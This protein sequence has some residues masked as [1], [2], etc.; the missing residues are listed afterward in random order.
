ML[1]AMKALYL[2]PDQ[3]P[4]EEPFVPDLSEGAEIGVYLA[5]LELIAE[6]LIITGDERII[7]VNSAACR[8]LE[9]SYRQLAGQALADLFT[10]ESAFLNARARLLIQGE[11][12]GKL[13]LVLPDGQT[14]EFSYIAAPRLRPG[15]HAIVLG[16]DPQPMLDALTV[17]ILNWQP[18]RAYPLELVFQPQ[19]QVR[20]QSL[21][22]GEVQFYWSPAEK[23]AQYFTSFPAVAA[24]LRAADETVSA[25]DFTTWALITACRAAAT[26]SR[27][28]QSGHAPLLSVNIS[29]EQLKSATLIAQINMALAAS[30]LDPRSL[31]LSIDAQALVLP[32]TL[33]GPA[34]Q[35][36]TALGV[37][38]AIDD[39]GHD[40][41]PLAYFTSYRLETLKLAP[42]LA[43]QVGIDDAS[44]AQIEAIVGLAAPLGIRVVAKGV[45][46]EA[47]RDFL[48]A[49]G[50]EFQHGPGIAPVQN[51][52]DFTNFLSQR[53][54]C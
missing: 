32:E 22:A 41:L 1:P 20:N 30:H 3:N 7:D 4:Q 28:E 39:F 49:L 24:A 15:I 36:I 16:Y 42:A 52:P 27:G 31:E 9:R 54:F 21:H 43:T 48:F 12:R 33:I 37:R 25:D 14:R 11:A 40:L 10:D 38:L 13:A 47:Q 29:A 18:P 5:L 6:G 44:T 50:I 2:N 26:W 17:P 19:L 53:L 45:K 8:L 23:P 34:L 35:A 46:D 51:A